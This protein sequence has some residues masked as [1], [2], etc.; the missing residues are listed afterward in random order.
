MS[1]SYSGSGLKVNKD[2]A[3]LKQLLQGGSNWNTA[4]LHFILSAITPVFIILVWQWAG[5]SNRVSGHLLPTPTAIL[6]AFIDLS[7]SGVLLSEFLVSCQRAI[8]GV[9]AGVF[10]ALILGITLGLVGILYRLIDPTMQLLRLTPSLAVAP[11]I[12]LWFGFGEMSK[13][14]I[15]ALGAFFPMYLSTLQSLREIDPKLMEVSKVLAFTPVKHLTSVLLPS[16]VPGILS[17]FRMAVAYG[18]LSLVVAELLGSQAGIGFLMSHAHTNAQ[19]EVVF[20]GVI[21]FAVMGKVIDSSIALLERK[22]LKWR[23]AISG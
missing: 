4:W 13:I 6:N 12:I 20:V 2:A 7:S 15:I 18:W 17:G 22:L 10:F 14:V 19:P 8:I 3:S 1:Q 23:N 9:F 16:A 11:L 5:D 21:I